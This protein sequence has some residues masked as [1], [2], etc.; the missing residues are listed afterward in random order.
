M[1]LKGRYGIMDLTTG[2]TIYR[3]IKLLKPN[4]Y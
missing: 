1:Y 3:I 4:Y 2:I